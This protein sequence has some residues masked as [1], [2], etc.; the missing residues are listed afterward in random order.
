MEERQTTRRYLE[1]LG[2]SVHRSRRNIKFLDDCVSKRIFPKHTFI[3]SKVLKYVCWSK[4]RVLR[5]REKILNNSLRECRDKLKEKEN[6]FEFNFKQFCV[7]NKIDGQERTNLRI[8]IFKKIKNS[9]SERDKKRDKKFEKL[10]KEK[11]AKI[12]LNFKIINLTNKTIPEK[13][14]NILRRGPSFPCGGSPQ[15]IALLGQ[16]DNLFGFLKGYKDF[17]KLPDLA[18]VHLKAKLVNCHE[19]LTKAFG[20]DRSNKYLRD[21]LNQNNDTVIVLSDKNHEIIIMERANYFESL[22]REFSDPSKFI[23][24]SQDPLESDYDNFKQLLR[25][26]KEYTNEMFYIKNKPIFKLKEGYGLGKTHKD[27]FLQENQMRPIVSS[28]GSLSSNFQKNFLEPVLS[29]FQSKFTV[30]SSKEFSSWFKSN[31]FNLNECDYVSLDICKLYPSVDTELLIEFLEHEIYTVQRPHQCLPRFR[32][33]EGNLLRPIPKTKLRP[34]LKAVLTK[35]TAFRRGNKFFR[36][37]SGLA[38]GD[39]C[40]PKLANLFLHYLEH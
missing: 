8:D 2:T 21:F 17:K 15:D 10:K 37:V 5:E 27:T 30:K 6:L 4:S 16:L 29:S 24:L 34:L 20:H 14:S 28:V 25:S 3:P 35:F 7:L 19:K 1:I 31:K 39:V 13:I 32:D 18:K 12:R 9:E 11:E 33:Q 23:E 38:M 40:S 26:V 22:F 36:Q